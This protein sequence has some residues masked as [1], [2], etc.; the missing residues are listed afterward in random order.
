[1][2]IEGLSVKTCGRCKQPKPE[3]DFH[4]AAAHKSGLQSS[5]KQC[6]AEESLARYHAKLADNPEYAKKKKEYDAKRRI[7][8][9]RKIREYDKIRAHQPN[10]RI[11]TAEGVKRRRSTLKVATPFWLSD[12]ERKD[13]RRLTA[14]AKTW[15]EKWGVPYHTD[16]IV[17][18]HGKDVCGLHVPWNLQIL[19]AP[20][21]YTKSN[22]LDRAV[23]PGN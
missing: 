22:K 3:A 4:R 16:H 21:N 18:L 1:M 2:E 17:P 9:A 7:V 12:S 14:L 6:K 15:S 23:Y 10:R 20:L 13:M 8:S 19:A 5:C 11:L